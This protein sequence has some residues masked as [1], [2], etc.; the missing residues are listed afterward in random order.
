MQQETSMPGPSIVKS[1]AAAA[2][3]REVLAGGV[4]SPVRAF[5]A[6]GGTPRFICRGKGAILTDI[7]GNESIDYIGSWGPMILGHADERIVAAASKVLGR[8]WSFGAPTELETR[9]AQRVVSDF[10]SI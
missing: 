4:N 9:L 2:A 7:D 1:E 6:V 5:K 8:G 10:D 3:A